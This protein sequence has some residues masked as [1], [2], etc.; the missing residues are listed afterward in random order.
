MTKSS[1]INALFTSLLLAASAAQADVLDFEGFANGQIMDTEYQPLVTITGTNNDNSAGVPDYAVVFDSRLNPTSDSDLQDP[2]TSNNPNLPGPFRPGN[3]LIIQENSAGCGDGICDNP[4][5]EGSRFSNKATG[6]ISFQFNQAIQLLS[7]DFFDVE[8]A[9]DGRTPNNRIRL[10]DTNNVEVLA[11][12]YYTPDTGGDNLWDQ[13]LFDVS[14]HSELRNIGRVDV[15]LAGS[16]A[17][18]NLKYNVVPVP[19]AFWLFGTALIGFI[20]FSRR[21]SV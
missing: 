14:L 17:I 9:E 12:T 16:G 15:Y 5:D 19:A 13:V 10:F 11:N 1:I 6:I 20:G 4:D 7:L 21:T 18:D 8:T 2:F 3:I